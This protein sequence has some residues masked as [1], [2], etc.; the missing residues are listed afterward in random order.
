M[1]T[2]E[3]AAAHDRG[4]TD[5]ETYRRIAGNA[6]V[7]PNAED[8][9]RLLALGLVEPDLRPGYYRTVDLRTAQQQALARA[10]EDL[11]GLALMA[12][13]PAAGTSDS[14]SE[15]LEGLDVINTRIEHEVGAAEREILSAQP[16]VRSPKRRERAHGRDVSALQRGVTMRTLYPM[17][18]CGRTPTREW[19]R[20]MSALGGEYR[21]LASPFSHGIVIDRRLAFITDSRPG[22]APSPDRAVVV[23]DHAVVTYLA[24]IFDTAWGR[25]LGWQTRQD[26]TAVTTPVQRA[27]LRELIEGRTQEAAGKALDMS[28]RAVEQHLAALRTA[29]QVAS[30]YAALAWWL[31]SDEAELD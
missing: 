30:T 15:V 2:N 18:A 21:L 5:S 14:G 1:S 27:I 7:E 26:R 23:R 9:R 11:A 16:H 29:L 24:G 13:L 31:R 17:A 10:R 28:S 20:E 4:I 8:L 19:V 3:A 25:A 22:V 6:P 12:S